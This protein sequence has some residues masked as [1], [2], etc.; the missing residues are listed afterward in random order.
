MNEEHNVT[1]QQHNMVSRI[2]KKAFE[3]G[4]AAC[5]IASVHPLSDDAA[6]LKQWLSEGHQGDMTY[7]ERYAD[8]RENISLLVSNAKSV[9]VVLY[10]YQQEQ[11]QPD[12]APR[13]AKYTFGDDYHY[14]IKTKLQLLLQ[15]IQQEIAP[16]EGRAFCDTAPV[17]ERR[18]AQQAGLGWIGT[19]KCLIHP[20]WGS[21][22]LIGELVIDLELEHDIPME[23]DCGNCGLCVSACPTQ[24]LT[25]S[26]VFHAERCISY[27]TIESKEPDIDDVYKPF[28]SQYVAGCDI[29]QDVC[30]WNRGVH[31]PA[32][33]LKQHDPLWNLRREDW[34]LMTTSAY[35]KWTK[36]SALNRISFQRMRR[37]LRA[38]GIQPF[39]QNGDENSTSNPLPD[40]V[41]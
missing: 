23:G 6:Y 15:F 12:D 41:S 26:G 17:F 14:V 25:L 20:K 27:L 19:N 11:Q 9:I 35:K 5:G 3:L 4:F 8:Q 33:D 34:Q 40:P 32:N 21:F 28:L 24:A 22:F 30:P 31:L 13:L 29:C 38:V 2:K 1:L 36:K 18:W 37:N 39:Q 10:S 16:A 7:L